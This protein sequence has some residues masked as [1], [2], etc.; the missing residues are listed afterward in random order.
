MVVINIVISKNGI[1]YYIR[2]NGVVTVIK[3]NPAAMAGR[4]CQIKGIDF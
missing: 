1:T 4:I 3:R 2:D